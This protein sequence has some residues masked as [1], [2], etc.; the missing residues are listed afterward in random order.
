M[1]TLGS[2][3]SP[4]L[5]VGIA[6]TM[7]NATRMGGGLVIT[8]PDT[9]TVIIIGRHIDTIRITTENDEDA[10]SSRRMGR[11]PQ[12]PYLDCS[13]LIS[14]KMFAMRR[15]TR[16]ERA[17]LIPSTIRRQIFLDHGRVMIECPRLSSNQELADILA[18]FVEQVR[19]KGKPEPKRVEPNTPKPILKSHRPKK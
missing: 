10:A 14:I 5:T 6:D 13:T 15:P 17:L 3:S 1:P 12:L 9:G 7:G 16:G 8:D 4:A 2:F 18:A 19:A 11:M